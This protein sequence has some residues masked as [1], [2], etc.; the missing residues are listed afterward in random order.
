[1]HL[2]LRHFRTIRAIHDAGGI[3]AAADQLGITQSALSHQVKTMETLTGQP[4]FVKRARPLRLS[5]AGL[6]VL[7]AAREILPRVAALEAEFSAME[8][9]QVG[10]LHIAV[11]CHA[12]FEWLLPVLEKFRIAWPEV[13][14]DIRQRLSF[15]ALPALRREQVDLVVSSDP[16]A[17]DTIQFSPLF[18]YAPVGL[19]AHN[20][21]LAKQSFV[22]AKDF[23]NQTLITYPMDRSKLDVFSLI[24]DPAG[25]T[26]AA[27]RT[28]ELTAMILMLVASGRGVAVLP[29][30]VARPKGVPQ[31]VVARPLLRPEGITRRLFAATREADT[32]RPHVAHFIRMARQEAVKMQRR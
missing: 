19:M 29:D 23:Q 4:L 2:E 6:R 20:H 10:R 14:L 30:W 17:E 16:E 13:D 7:A 26:P 9:G 3:A 18:D 12:C 32:L 8:V 21:R 11:E 28:V 25:V 22:V 27:T 24:L 31:G 1:M 15:D 5:D